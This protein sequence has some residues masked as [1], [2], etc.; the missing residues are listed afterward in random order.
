MHRQIP[1]AAV[2]WR[3]GAMHR[4]CAASGEPMGAGPSSLCASSCRI[5]L[6]ELLL[7]SLMILLVSGLEPALGQKVFTN[8]WA[9]HIPGGREEAEKI[10]NKH[11]FINY[12][13]VF[14]D[15]YHFKHRTVAKR[16]LSD[17]RNTHVRLLRDPKVTWAEQQ[18]VKRRKKR[19]IFE[20]LHDPLLK[21]QWYLYNDNHR[22][23]N[24]RAA[25]NLGYTGKGVVVSIL[26]DGIEKTHP[27]LSQNYDPDAS[28]DVN[29]GD[30][31]PQ[32]RYT[33]LND[34][35]HGTRC[36]GEVAAVANNGVCGVGVAY[37][38]RIGGVR[39][40]DG[41]VTDMVEAQSL[42][43][44]PQHID[45][46]SASWGP[47]DDGKTVDGPAKLAKEAFLRGVTEGRGGL[48]SIFVWAS[49]NGGR[50]KDS[51]NCD[52]YTNS[53]YT[54]SISSS[55]QNGNVPWYSEACSSTLAT[56]YSS[57]GLTEK[58]IITTDLKAKCTDSHTGTSASAPL[59]AGIIA[60]AL[61]A[62]KN[63]TWRDMQHLVVQ[64]S[65]PGHLITND[66]NINGVGR[67]VS[68]SYG[69]GLLDASEIVALAKTWTNVG[70][71]RKCVITMVNEPKNIGGHLSVNK[72]VDACFNSL[73]HVTLLEHVQARLTLSYNRRGNLAIHLISP[74][75][76]R[77]TLLHPRPHDY[78]SE[79]FK[80]WAFMTTHSWDE[81]PSGSWTL[82]IE[83]VAGASDYGTLTQFILVLYGTGPLD[84]SQPGNGN[85]KTLDLKQTCLEC[86]SG[87]YL[88][89]QG[90]V[91]ECP[92]GF[93]V[94]SIPVNY[95]VGN[96]ISPAS[97][98]ACLPCPQPCLTCSA[99]SLDACLSCTPH[100]S[101][102][103]ITGT[104]DRIA[105]YSRE[106][107]GSFMVDQGNTGVQPQPTTQLPVTVAILS[108]MAI[109]AV[110]AGVFLL[111]QLRSGAL[112]KFQSMESGTGGFSLGRNRVVSYHGIPTVWGDDT[113]NTDSENEEFDV[114]N[115]RTAFIKTQSAL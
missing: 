46:Y 66:W 69:Y 78:S 23:L 15:F 13:H 77:S 40:L 7:C 57:G 38:A 11:G 48:G 47:E 32:P 56:T 44:N 80:D 41:E 92:R 21:E 33:Q 16:S 26:D 87:F 82:E 91:T 111:L 107:P 101:L 31:D 73:N 112:I 61:E 98:P 35:R 103:T 83:N 12:G 104:C 97:V 68:H 27:D 28:Y 19:D 109:V 54:L 45:I 51:C 86:D 70:P 113:V 58:Q 5:T 52:G 43:L 93:A 25:W 72:S 4:D 88:Y 22:D 14:G 29:D 60:L 85:C 17:H 90:C 108:C 10:A 94:G 36:A 96:N 99:L 89:M 100:R 20:Q 34:N 74:A 53:I 63:L 24:A 84:D 9:V 55:T 105:Q 42:S 3:K 67:K 6:V 18:V 81:N 37:N 65:H 75:G 76:T 71:Q 39:M 110:F 115:E 106:S 30:P 49:G 1:W 79:G 50:D 114:Q 62:N 8:T 59:A 95:T 2:A 102:N 64:T